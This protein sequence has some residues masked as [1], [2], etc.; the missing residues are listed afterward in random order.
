MIETQF[1]SK[2]KTFQSDGGGEFI[3]TDFVH[4]LENCGIIHQLSYLGTLE[5]DAVV[6]RK[7]RHIVEISSMMFFH[8][9][10]ANYLWV[11]AFSQL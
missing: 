2:I 11:D 10:V 4:H 3:R 7:H 6:E 1:L 5:Q 8:A 9:R